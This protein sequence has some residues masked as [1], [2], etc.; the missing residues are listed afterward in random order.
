MLDVNVLG[1]FNV[2]AHVADAINRDRNHPDGSEEHGPFWTTEEEQGVIIN[3]ASAADRQ[4][5]P[6]SGSPSVGPVL[7]NMLVR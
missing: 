1:T 2:N 3:F 6:S 5:R 4:R 7:S